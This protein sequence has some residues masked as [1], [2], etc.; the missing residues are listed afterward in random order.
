MGRAARLLLTGFVLY[1]NQHRV[2]QSSP[3]EITPAGRPKRPPTTP[4]QHPLG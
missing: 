3:N 4:D 2:S 1:F